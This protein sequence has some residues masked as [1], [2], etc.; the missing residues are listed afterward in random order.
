MRI[1]YFSP[2]APVRSGISAYSAELLP[3]LAA[4]HDVAVY[5]ADDA[6]RASTSPGAPVPPR[7][8]SPKPIA[9][10]QLCSSHAFVPRQTLDPYD[11]IVYQLGNATCHE[12]MWP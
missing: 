4:K 1:A 5:V 3:L 2:L 12:Y 10:W 7:A 11:L 6:Y 8:H 9:A